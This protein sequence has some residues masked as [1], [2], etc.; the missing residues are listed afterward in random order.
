MTTPKPPTQPQAVSREV[1][2]ASKAKDLETLRAKPE[3]AVKFFLSVM[4]HK[5]IA[6]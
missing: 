5:W 6:C 1:R 2:F 4:T 3:N